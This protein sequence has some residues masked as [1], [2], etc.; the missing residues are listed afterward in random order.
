MNRAPYAVLTIAS[1]ALA[2]I[3]A[4]VQI[5][6]HPTLWGLLPSEPIAML[7]VIP[8][9]LACLGIL[10][11][12]LFGREK[13]LIEHEYELPR[14]LGKPL[15]ILACLGLMLVAWYLRSHNHFMGDGWAYL[16]M[17]KQDFFLREHEP[18]DFFLHQ[19][20]FRGL[21]AIGIRD[22]VYA[23]SL[24]HLALLP[25]Y[26]FVLWKI[27]CLL[28]VQRLS[29]ISFFLF[30]CATGAFQLFFGYVESYT[31]LNLMLALYYYV[32][33]KHIGRSPDRIPWLPGAILALAM[34]LHLSAAALT[35]MLLNQCKPGETQGYLYYDSPW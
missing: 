2:L 17:V 33:L 12:A 15:F 1:C 3:S 28:A 14:F 19:L 22:S 11:L 25:V 35:P 27:S 4:T 18:L 26:L 31:L 30:L 13:V 21:A 29:R 32:S 34:A 6:G 7:W 5:S 24:P 8:G 10:L 20:I 23:Y 16:K 9:T